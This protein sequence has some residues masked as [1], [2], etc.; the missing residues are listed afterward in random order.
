MIRPSRRSLLWSAAAALGAPRFALG[1]DPSGTGKP[2]LVVFVEGGWDVTYCLDPKLSCSAP[3]GG[4]CTV[5]GPELDELRSIPEDREAVETF[6]GIP[7]VVNDHKRPSVR[8]FFQRWHSRA[9]V[10]NGVWTGSIAHEPCRYRI[11]TGHPD[12]RHPDL[13]TITGFVHGGELPLGSVDLSGWSITGEL[14]SSSGRIGNQSQIAALLGDD[15]QLRAPS[16]VPWRY[17]LFDMDPTDEDAVEAF[18]RAR[19]E[20]MRARFSDGGG[21]NDRALDDLLVSLDRGQRFRERSAQIL[22]SLRIGEQ[23]GF[24]QQLDIAVNLLE[25]GL[26]SSVTVET[27]EEWDTHDRNIDQHLAYERLFFGLS[28]LMETLE[29]RGLLDRVV[30]AVLSEM[31]RTPLRNAA[32]GKDHW[33]HTSALL[34]GA[35]RGDA[36][37]GG[38]DHLLESRPVD[39]ASGALRETGDLNKYDNLVA[40]ILELRDV[41]P[42]DWLPG[43]VPFRGAHPV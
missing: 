43:V 38:T 16:G 39:L 26:C 4:P 3:D 6:G 35:V 12:G 19:A 34:L 14:A 36:V 15:A 37:S 1:Q 31:T 33:G 32:S 30:V 23:A 9:H 24:Q 22:S 10:V 27:R 21:R 25:A 13:A 29:A 28:G 17:P 20:R 41:D 2:L 11:L 40:G 7:V 42:G 5:Q 8:A 18:V